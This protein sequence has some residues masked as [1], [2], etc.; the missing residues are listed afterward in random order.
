[1]NDKTAPVA[2]TDEREAFEK[3]AAPYFCISLARLPTGGYESYAVEYTWNAWKARA[4]LSCASQAD[5]PVAQQPLRWLV[6]WTE[7]FGESQSQIFETAEEAHSFVTFNGSGTVTPLYTA[8]VAQS[9]L[10][11]SAA[12]Q[13]EPFAW[14]VWNNILKGI[15]PHLYLR[16]E[17]ELLEGLE[18]Q[19]YKDGPAYRIQPVYAAPI[20]QQEPKPVSHN[21]VL[22][23]TRE[24]FADALDADAM[25][26]LRNR[27]LEE[28]ATVCEKRGIVGTTGR[29]LALDIAKN[30]RALKTTAPQEQPKPDKHVYPDDWGYCINCGVH[31]D[32]MSAMIGVCRGKKGS[33]PNPQEPDL[34]KDALRYRYLR[35]THTWEPIIWEAIDLPADHDYAKALDAAVDAAMSLQ[36][37]KEAD[38]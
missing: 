1:M 35:D 34:L 20:P 8:P 4:L 10:S 27:T 28:A 32:H 33:T 19:V 13:A 22:E 11:E 26:E 9:P 3:W 14:I 17:Q 18:E 12:Q 5:K 24:A 23:D 29:V 38:K 25:L 30:I 6:E 37:T 15:G 36:S 7:R 16:H 2:I 31:E 21:D